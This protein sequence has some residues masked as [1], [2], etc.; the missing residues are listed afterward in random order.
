MTEQTQM[1][2]VIPETV[3]DALAAWDAGELVS[4]VDMGGIGPG[5]EQCIQIMAF[6][7]MRRLDGMDYED[8]DAINKA[9]EEAIKTVSGKLRPSG[10]QA[11]AAKNL[12]YIVCKK[13]YR[14]ALKE[15]AVK[16]RR[17]LVQ[18][19]FPALASV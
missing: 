8:T 12:A 5:Y 9:A 19:D 15:D 6:E 7:I 1:H 3:E 13:G 16:D 18:K 14:T 4:T 17:I 11:G 10:A 2:D